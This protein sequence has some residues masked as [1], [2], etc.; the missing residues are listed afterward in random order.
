MVPPGLL[1]INAS[2]GFGERYLCRCR[3]F[4]RSIRGKFARLHNDGMIDVIKRI[5]LA[6]SIILLAAALIWIPL[7]RM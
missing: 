6:T 5:T 1:R 3:N 4:R 2:V 7:N